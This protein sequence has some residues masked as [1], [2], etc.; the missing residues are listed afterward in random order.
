MAMVL[1]KL[2]SENRREGL[3]ERRRQACH[4]WLSFTLQQL[5]FEYTAS[6]FLPSILRIV[7]VH[8]SRGHIVSRTK[9]QISQ[10]FDLTLRDVSTE[11][12]LGLKY[13]DLLSTSMTRIFHGFLMFSLW[14][15]SLS[16]TLTFIWENVIRVSLRESLWMGGSEYVIPIWLYHYRD[17]T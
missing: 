5:Y 12:R 11:N 15:L 13:F 6:T 9:T 4:K 3:A 8:Q 17:H 10:Y 16:P 14:N 2:H 7:S 1:F